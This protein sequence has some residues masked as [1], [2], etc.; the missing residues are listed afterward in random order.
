MPKYP[1]RT[2]FTNIRASGNF[3]LMATPEHSIEVRVRYAETDQM[4]VVYHSNYLIWCEIGRTELM[5]ELGAPYSEVE[6]H[7]LRLAVTEASLRYHAPARYDD[8]V[9]VTAY[10]GDVRSRTV[11]FKYLITNADT[12]ARLVS[13][14]TTLAAITH[15]GRMTTLPTQLREL[16][17]NASK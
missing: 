3:A 8:R 2:T 9:R 4:Q 17:T 5:R 12:G 1:R 13:A 10:L 11:E 15:E 7:G 6:H 16:L 14:A